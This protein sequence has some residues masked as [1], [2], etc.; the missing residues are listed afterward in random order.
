MRII[1]EDAFRDN[2]LRQFGIDE[3]DA[4]D[5]VEHAEQIAAVELNEETETVGIFVGKPKIGDREWVLLVSGRVSDEVFTPDVAFKVPPDIAGTSG[6]LNPPLEILQNI[7]ERFGLPLTIGRRIAKFIAN[8]R[9]VVPSIE[10]ARKP[11]IQNAGNVPLFISWKSR[12]VIQADCDLCFAID[13]NAYKKAIHELPEEAQTTRPDPKTHKVRLIISEDTVDLMRL[14]GTSVERA[15][16]TLNKSDDQGILDAGLHQPYVAVRWFDDG[17]IV[18]L[19][20]AISK[21]HRED[22]KMWVLEV[23]A[24]LVLALREQLPAGKIHRGQKVFAILELVAKSFGVPVV[25]HPDMGPS[26]F[27]SGIWDG[28]IPKVMAPSDELVRMSGSLNPDKHT[29]SWIWAFAPRLYREWWGS[30]AGKK[31]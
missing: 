31:I 2:C 9:I 4:L 27:Y 15:D 30:V 20:G 7:V 3:A 17:Q 26:L 28:Q 23:T 11:S 6:A 24:R 8:E 29:C 25:C 21:S 19:Q 22:N 12:A 5:V 18:F 14:T 16:Q 10:E 1:I 13:L